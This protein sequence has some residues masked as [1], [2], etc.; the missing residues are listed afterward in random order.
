[1]KTIIC[2]LLF[3]NFSFCQAQ[4]QGIIRCKEVQPQTGISNT[5]IYKPPKNL[6]LPDKIEALVLYQSH[7]DFFSK[8]LPVNKVGNAYQFVFKAPDSVS[9][10]IMGMVDRKVNIADYSPLSAFKKK[11][12]DNNRESGFVFYVRD[13][14][15]ESFVDKNIQLAKLLQYGYATPSLDIKTSNA[16]LINLY[17]DSY[18]LYPKLKNEDSY[19]DYLTI[20][21]EDKKD[22]VRPQLLLYCDKME[23]IQNNETKWLN[24]V[25]M[26]ESLKMS[27]E[28]I[29][30][31]NKILSVFPHGILAKKHFW[32][33]FYKNIETD[34][35]QSILDSMKKYISRFNDNSYKTRD[36]FYSDIISKILD[37]KEWKALSKYE[38]LIS[39]KFNLEYTYNNFA[40][41]LLGKELDTPGSDLEIAKILSRKSLN[42]IEE[43]IK[44]V[45]TNGEQYENMKG[46]HNK[47]SNTYALILY[48]LGQYD[49][50]FY[51]QDA[52]YQR[53]NELNIGGLERYAVYAEKVKGANYA[54][55]IIEQQLLNGI[56]SPVMLTQL[57]SIYKHLKLP[58]N[59]FTKLQAK[60]NL[61]ARQEK[62]GKIKAKLGTV[63]AKDFTLKNISGQ[64]V[65]L[66]SFK[67]KIVVLN[68]WGVW[69]GPCVASLP[70][71]QDAVN[72]YKQ[73]TSVVFLFID[74]WEHKLPEKM[75]QST[76]KFIKDNNYNFNVLLDVNDKVVTAYKVAAVPAKYVIDKKGDIVFMGETSNIELEIENAKH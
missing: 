49:S 42:Y 59:E 73:D 53:G 38:Q 62:A 22:T 37:K 17:E 44:E 68:F 64:D 11:V 9:V 31:E 45:D 71:M 7:E 30:L 13:K 25:A 8:Y 5:Y 56:I 24:T 51:Y 1:M 3:F 76:T 55:Q 29:A 61:Q 60:Y 32:K 39:D 63:K 75:L 70:A 15:N 4:H 21:Y 48:K 57:Q 50:A 12:V 23:E 72:N 6:L 67:N 18:K 14:N 10:L 36:D 74:V 66:S 35:E 47:Y 46:A 41:K 33:F 65:S 58:E 27:E 34:T 43:Q 26:Y 69:C 52:M 20:L 40:W 54:R 19:A 2:V 16:F 28:K